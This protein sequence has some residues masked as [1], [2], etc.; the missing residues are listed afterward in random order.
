MRVMVLWSGGVE[1]TSLLKWVLENT[2]WQVHAHHVRMNN[3]ER[4][5]SMEDRA[6]HD[7]LPRLSTLRKF[8]GLSYSDASVCRGHVVPPDYWLL[9]PIGAAVARHKGCDALLRGWCSEDDWTRHADPTGK[10][11]RLELAHGRGQ[12]GRWREQLRVLEP[13]IP[14]GARL[15]DYCPWLEPHTWAKAQHVAHLGDWARHTW[16]CR[17]PKASRP[18]GECFSCHA[19]ESA[20]HGNSAIPEVQNE[21]DA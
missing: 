8:S 21:V 19:R 1:S 20:L 15:H 2:D 5:E 9:Y 6:L 17:R 14:D 10:L 11:L 4:R 16:S 18:C 12:F 7:L 13:F 3:S